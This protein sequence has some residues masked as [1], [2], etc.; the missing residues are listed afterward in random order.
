[1]DVV[2]PSES[3]RFV[4]NDDVDIVVREIGHERVLAARAAEHDPDDIRIGFC[5]A[6]QLS[7]LGA[8]AHAASVVP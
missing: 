1:M 6:E 5:L 2:P 3:A 4:P 7:D 8:T